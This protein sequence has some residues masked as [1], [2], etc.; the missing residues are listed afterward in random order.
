MKKTDRHWNSNFPVVSDARL[1]ILLLDTEVLHRQEMN[2]ALTP[3][4]STRGYNMLL[5]M[6][7]RARGTTLQP[8]ANQ[9]AAERK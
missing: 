1:N 6:F 4:Y 8:A 5:A 7:A 3:S 9:R 2:L